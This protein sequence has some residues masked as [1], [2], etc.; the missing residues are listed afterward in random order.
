MSTR[1]GLPSFPASQ[2]LSS[3][4][5]TY[6]RL[7]YSPRAAALARSTWQYSSPAQR[8][9]W[10]ANAELCLRG[11]PRWEVSADQHVESARLGSGTARQRGVLGGRRP[12]PGCSTH[13]GGGTEPY[14]P[15]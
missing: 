4:S 3:A 1:G 6:P 10:I 8:G 9:Y 2:S 12:L 14:N 15:L 5:A 11:Q 13:P 7:S